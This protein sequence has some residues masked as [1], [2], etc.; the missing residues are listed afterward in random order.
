LDVRFGHLWRA[1]GQEEPAAVPVAKA[2]LNTTGSSQRHTGVLEGVTVDYRKVE[3]TTRSR[4]PERWR[5]Y[6]AGRR[7][8]L[9]KSVEFQSVP[10]RERKNGSAVHS[11]LGV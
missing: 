9:M 2:L 11:D 8:V 6:K 3:S 10:S 4:K 1:G 5:A 7:Q